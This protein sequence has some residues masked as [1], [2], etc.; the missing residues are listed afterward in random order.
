VG[1]VLDELN[2]ESFKHAI[3]E[4]LKLLGEGQTLVERCRVISR[5]YF[6]L[7]EVGG[8]RYREVYQ[9]LFDIG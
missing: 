9:S 4:L 7:D 6:S 2:D 8:P 1:L 3:D 5:R